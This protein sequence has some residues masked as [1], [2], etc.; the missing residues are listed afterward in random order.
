MELAHLVASWSK[1][2]STKVG[3]VIVGAFR[4]IRSVGYNGFP[5]GVEDAF[6]EFNDDTIQVNKR[7]ERP[8]KYFWTEHAE[9]NAIYNAVNTNIPIATATMYL[10]WF[11]CADCTRAIIQSGLSGIVCGKKPDDSNPAFTESFRVSLIMLLE[12]G[13]NIRYVEY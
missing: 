5:R 10:T 2:P 8:E 13:I 6:N 4:E 12:A 7:H 1:D 11:P 9:R 3:A